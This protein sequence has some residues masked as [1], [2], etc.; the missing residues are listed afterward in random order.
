MTNELANITETV[1]GAVKQMQQWPVALLIIAVL[2]VA[3]SSLKIIGFFPNRFI[4]IS[5]IALGGI[6]NGFLGDISSVSSQQRHPLAVLV[7]QGIM[8]GFVA[9]ILHASLLKRFEKFI[10]FLGG[11]SG[12]TVIIGKDDIKP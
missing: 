12:D 3:G 11:R 8:L 2:I 1:A 9:W 10:P 7:L 6:G 5:V 4:P